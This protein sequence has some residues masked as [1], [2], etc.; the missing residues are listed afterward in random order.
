M[1]ELGR[2]PFI[3]SFFAGVA[4]FVSPC[5]LPLIP[6]Y[7]SFITGASLEELES[8]KLSASSILLKSLFFVLG[9]S[10]VFVLLG[11]F[12]GLLGGLLARNA[13]LLRMLGGAI[14]IIFG[15]HLLGV[16]RIAFLYREKRME[17][18]R[19]KLGLAGSF[20]FGL[21]FAFSWTPCVGPILAS[22]LALASTQGTVLKGTLL[23]TV[24]SLG[25]G[26]PFLLTGILIKK[27]LAIFKKI[28][29]FYRAI[30]VLSGL[31]LIAIGILILT[32]SLNFFQKL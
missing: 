31:L 26:I 9:F 11:A 17:V 6:A 28:K 7:I 1:T 27:A 15:L 18:K 22:I 3:A 12:A 29:P 2:F 25:L 16:F 4:T 10:L 21:A 19:V 14:A 32:N 13:S 24:Y 20:L 23:L 8:S 30:E 5:I